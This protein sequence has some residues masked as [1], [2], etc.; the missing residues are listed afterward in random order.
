MYELN[1]F[2][3]SDTREALLKQLY[4]LNNENSFEFVCVKGFRL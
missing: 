4:I 1:E 3:E 2:P